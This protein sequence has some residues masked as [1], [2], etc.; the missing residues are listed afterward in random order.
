[1]FAKYWSTQLRR[2]GYDT[3][4]WYG[5][6]QAV[7]ARFI[8]NNDLSR[9]HED[10]PDD[11]IPFMIWYPDFPNPSTLVELARMNTNCIKTF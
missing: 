1:M 11:G 6:Q 7:T 3:A 5:I 4:Q 10:S 8:M 9:A 2:S